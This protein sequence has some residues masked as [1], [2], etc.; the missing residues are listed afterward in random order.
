MSNNISQHPVPL[1][2]KRLMKDKYNGALRVDNA[3]AV[4]ELFFIDSRLVYARTTIPEERLGEILCHGGKISGPQLA[5]VLSSMAK[6]N[7]KEKIGKWLIQKKMLNHRDIYTGLLVQLKTIAVAALSQTSGEWSL[8]NENSA[9][10]EN[11]LFELEIPSI[12]AEGIDKIGRNDFFK[13]KLGPGKLKIL[14]VS[15]NFQRLF[16]AE[17][18]WLYARLASLEHEAI[19]SIMDRLD[20]T[21]EFFWK[22][23]IFFYLLNMIDFDLAPVAQPIRDEEARELEKITTAL[24]AKELDHYELLGVS[25]DASPTLI[26]K[27]YYSAARRFH[28]DR[29]VDDPEL[30]NKANIVLAAINN[31]FDTLSDDIKR[32]AYDEKRLN[33]SPTDTT[34][35]AGPDGSSRRDNAWQLYLQ[36]RHHY[37]QKKFQKAAASLE[38]ALKQDD[39]NPKYWYLLGV[40][41]MNTPNGK[42]AA[43]KNLQTAHEKDPWNPD[44]IN[45]LGMVFYSENLLNRAKS[46]FKKALE[47]DP[48]NEFARTKLQEMNGISTRKFSISSILKSSKP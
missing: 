20:L 34:N 10:R 8:V 28:P 30:K 13:E 6:E 3:G 16:S 39:S 22:K 36:G 47:L 35:G 42:N 19:S 41:Q 11:F 25:K 29:A 2:L 24:K 33:P 15:S 32:S 37:R 40:C 1:V 17:D 14:P 38:D 21:E 48:K 44:P 4:R 31:A 27:A 43:V 5:D 26:K 45:A 23:I 46:F 18:N 7:N 9:E 12:I